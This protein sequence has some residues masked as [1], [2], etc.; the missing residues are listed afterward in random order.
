MGLRPRMVPEND[1]EMQGTYPAAPDG[2]HPLEGLPLGGA[3]RGPGGLPLSP[4]AEL[5]LLTMR[6]C[7]A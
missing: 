1:D 3:L 5:E 2:V 4:A 7:R 6:H